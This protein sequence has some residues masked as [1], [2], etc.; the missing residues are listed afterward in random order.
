MEGLG[1][2]IFIM[3]LT[4]YYLH[5]SVMVVL[6]RHGP[7][8]KTKTKKHGIGVHCALRYIIVPFNLNVSIEFN[9]M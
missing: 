2:E 7:A 4:A 6:E 8:H 3:S 5:E 9:S 1:K